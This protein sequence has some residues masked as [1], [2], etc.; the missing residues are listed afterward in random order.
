[1]AC[2]AVVKKGSHFDGFGKLGVSI[3][4]GTLFLWEKMVAGGTVF[5]TCG[6]GWHRCY[7]TSHLPCT[8]PQSALTRGRQTTHKVTTYEKMAVVIK[9][10]YVRGAGLIGAAA[11]YGMYLA[12]ET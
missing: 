12:G 10:M 3:T 11:G 2:G 4:I 5:P 7:T 9:D 1:M 6:G 8:M